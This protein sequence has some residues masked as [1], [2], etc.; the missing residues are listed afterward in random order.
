MSQS[1][2]VKTVA[3][4]ALN[5]ADPDL[6]LFVL[7]LWVLQLWGILQV[8]RMLYTELQSHL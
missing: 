5:R 6:D 2:S 8:R 4:S 1:T 3:Q 7:P